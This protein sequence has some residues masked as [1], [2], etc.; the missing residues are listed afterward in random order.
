MKSKTR[1][2]IGV[3]AV[4]VLLGLAHLVPVDSAA[5]QPTRGG[6]IT[7]AV[8]TDP[9]SPGPYVFG[10]GAGYFVNGNIYNSLLR[11]DKDGKLVPDLAESYSVTESRIY[12]FKLHH[13][14]KF[15]EGGEVTA[16]DVRWSYEFYMSGKAAASRGP[17]L[18]ALIETIKAVDKYTVR[19]TLKQPNATFLQVVAL[20]D[21]EDFSTE[22]TAELLG[23]SVPAV[24]S[25][26]LRGRLKLRER[27]NPYF[28]R[29]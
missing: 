26:L 17:L 29:G 27:L 6:K 28:K 7:A 22:E 20:R 2:R 4:V 15:H 11:P 16:E 8:G 21:V 1:S 5:Q 9:Y 13:G 19:I 14:V 25:R 12:T 3:L 18:K 10:G 23:L 24:K